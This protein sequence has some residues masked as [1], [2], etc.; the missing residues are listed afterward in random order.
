MNERM[1]MSYM[2]AD[3][4]SHNV[5]IQELSLEE[6]DDVNG[7]LPFIVAGYLAF[8]GAKTAVALVAG[9]AGFATVYLAAHN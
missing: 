8:Y 6:Q 5:G 2:N 4:A 7:G 3:A 9:A 1:S